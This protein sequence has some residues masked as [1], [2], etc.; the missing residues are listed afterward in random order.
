VFARCLML[1]HEFTD[2]VTQELRSGAIARLRNRRKRVFQKLIHT[3]CKGYV[4]HVSAF[5]C[6]IIRAQ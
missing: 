6:Y 2:E 4:S 1:L 5:L 3:E